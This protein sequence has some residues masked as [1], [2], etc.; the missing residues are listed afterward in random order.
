M[1][2]NSSPLELSVCF[3]AWNEQSN[4]KECITDAQS[5]LSSI[6]PSGNYELLVVDNASTDDTPRI[7]KQLQQSDARVQL[8]RHETNM[9]YSGSHR[10]ALNRANGKYIAIID[11]DRQHTTDDIKVAIALVEKTNCDVVFGW[12]KI[13]HDGPLRAIFSRGLR[14]TSRALIGHRL[15]DINCGFRLFTLDAAR[16]IKINEKINS[17]GPEIYCEARR[18]GL[19]IGEITVQHFPRE[20]GLGI[21]GTLLPLLRSTK[22]FIN[23]LLRLR[24]KY[25][26]SPKMKIETP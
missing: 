12:K 16:R 25:G 11:G 19:R 7:V 20:Q 21:H 4:I 26:S 18:L 23:Y 8:V 15:H 6:V 3:C 14:I 10:T 5:S 22:A 2:L 9:L 24:A 13:R 17:V 1:Q